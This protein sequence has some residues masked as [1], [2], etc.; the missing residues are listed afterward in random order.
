M[1]LLTL[2]LLSG[3]D[4]GSGTDAGMCEEGAQVPAERLVVFMVLS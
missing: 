4:P 2:F 1:Q 3:I